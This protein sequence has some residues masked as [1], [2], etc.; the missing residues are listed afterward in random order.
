[1]R[2]Y[3]QYGG[4][5]LNWKIFGSSGHIQRPEGGVLQNYKMCFTNFHIKTIVNTRNV[6]KNLGPHDFE[7]FP[8]FN[9]VDT[10][11]KRVNGPFNPG[12][13]EVA[14]DDL[15]S[16]MYIN[17]YCTKSRE[18]FEKKSKRGS[19]TNDFKGED[20]WNDTERNSVEICPLLEIP[21]VRLSPTPYLSN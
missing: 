16:I 14:G 7:Y 1:L 15:F 19:Q 5:T 4:L 11:F 20:F 18:D 12:I 10:N 2:A 13:L 17:H 9:A 3:E 6:L 8:G 21:F